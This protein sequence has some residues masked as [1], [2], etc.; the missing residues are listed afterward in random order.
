MQRFPH[1]TSTHRN[2]D[3]RRSFDDPPANVT[4][5]LYSRPQHGCAAELK[6]E[7]SGCSLVEAASVDVDHFRVAH[8]HTIAVD[9][10]NLGIGASDVLEG[11]D[12]GR[13]RDRA[14]T[15]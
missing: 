5:Y 14:G 11:K 7:H 9:V 2:G 12:R 6:S 4:C 13:G 15:R 1:P 10:A 3:L 8:H